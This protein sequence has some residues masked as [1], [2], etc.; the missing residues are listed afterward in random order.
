MAFPFKS[1][2]FGSAEGV[3][4]QKLNDCATKDPAHFVRGSFGDHIALVQD[5]LI[6]LN[7]DAFLDAKDAASFTTEAA[8][9]FY[10][11]ITAKV[12]EF[13][14]NNHKPKPIL[15]PWQKTA[16]NVVGRQTISFLDDDMAALEGIPP[17]PEPKPATDIFIFFSGVQDGPSAGA[18]LDDTAVGHGFLMRPEMQD[19]ANRRKGK[20]LAIGGSLRRDQEESGI[21]LAF[22]FLRD[23]MSTPP[24]KHIVY[25]FSAG[26][27]NSLNLALRQ[28]D[29]VGGSFLSAGRDFDGE[30]PAISPNRRLDDRALGRPIPGAAHREIERVTLSECKSQ[31]ELEFPAP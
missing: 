2:Q 27:T 1:K 3:T 15:Q 12:V 14:K 19:I 26:G 23:N 29:G 17:A 28:S 9:A 13:Y 6:Q 20:F 7:Q 5:A 30:S 4:R 24:W 25:G 10:G 11:P 31:I 22:K 16:D 21:A 8:G 18:K